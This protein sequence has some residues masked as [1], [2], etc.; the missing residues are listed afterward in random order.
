MMLDK[1]ITWFKAHERL[2]IV[3]ACLLVTVH[4]YSKG[5]DYFTRRDQLQAQQA[6]QKLAADTATNLALTSQLNDLKKQFADEVAQLQK[7]IQT[8]NQ[9]TEKQ[10][11]QDASMTEV[12]L[13][14][15][16]AGLINVRTEE[17]QASPVQGTLQVSDNAAHVTVA[18]L[19]DLPT[20][21]ANLI[22][23]EKQLADANTLNAKNE[24]VIV[25]DAT[26]LASEKKLHED[27]VKTLK[28]ANKGKWLNGFKWG[29]I[30][31][32]LGSLF[33]HKP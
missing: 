25:S 8:R 11:E 28:A 22:D 15:R 23:T 20:C 17:V 5:I 13:A 10:K 3:L 4:F 29:V 27:D 21:Q 18:R 7:Q 1:Y 24:G 31:G 32:F 9:V 16:W 2:V 14:Q 30:T 33:V 12:E 19:E 26:V 6:S